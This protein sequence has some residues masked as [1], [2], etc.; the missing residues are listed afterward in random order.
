MTIVC[1]AVSLAVQVLTVLLGTEGAIVA[2]PHVLGRALHTIVATMRNTKLN[3]AF[4]TGLGE[5]A[6]TC[7]DFY[8]LFLFLGVV[9]TTFYIS[10]CIRPYSL[11]VP[12]FVPK[13]RPKWALSFWYIIDSLAMQC[14]NVELRVHIITRT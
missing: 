14:M 5:S 10:Q 1:F 9:L 7:K 4:S 2:Y 12:C 3:H 13:W 8:F 11:I 6:V